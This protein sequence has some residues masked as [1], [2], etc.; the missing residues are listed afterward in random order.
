MV[1]SLYDITPLESLVEQGYT[2]LTPNYRLARHIKTQWDVRRIAAGDRV[3]EPL[4]VQ[5]LESWLLAQWELAVSLNLL[6]PV[7]PLSA[8]QA[9]ELWRQVIVQQARQ[10]PEFRLLRPAA[11]AEL[12]SQAYEALRRWRVD[13]RRPSIRQSFELE[14]DC[15]SFLSW[16]TL[17]E[18]RLTASRQCTLPDCLTQLPALAGRLP[19]TPVALV[20]CG[21]IAPLLRAA[22][23]A[24][25][26]TTVEV[27]PQ[28]EPGECLFHSFSD[29]R[30]ELQ[31]VAAWA[32]G[33]HRARP[34]ATIGI[35]LSNT[36]DGVALEYLLRREFNCLGDSYTGLP[37]NFSSGIPL[38]QTPLVR[39]AL[40]A[41]SMGLEH[42]TVQVVESLLHSRFLDLADAHSALAQYFIMHLYTEGRQTLTVAAVQHSATHIQLGEQKGLVLGQCLRAVQGMRALRHRAR[43]S[44]WAER[45]SAVLSLWGWP[46]VGTLDS[47]EFQQLELWYRTLDE[48][49]A[50]D[51]VCAPIDFGDALRLLRECCSRQIS[52][53][54][55]ADSAVQ[56]L[57]PLEAAGLAF[58]HLWLCGMQGAS[59]PAAPRPN[60]LI[61][62]GLQAQLR[63][64]HASAEREWDFSEALITQY[65]RTCRT[66]H[67]SYS[68]HIDG[69]G[70]LPSA[71]L[72][73][74]TYQPVPDPPLVAPQWS[75]SYSERVI[76]E[77]ADNRGPCLQGEQLAT[78][79]G[80]SSLLE[81]QSRCPFRAFALHRL[82]V[83]PLGSFN[84]A[85]SQAERGA[86]L[87]GALFALWGEICDSTALHAL[88]AE[89]Q[90]HTIARAVQ[91]AL[92][93]IPAR[94]R[95]TLGTT[96]WLLEAQRLASLLHEWLTVERTR[97]AFSVLQREEGKT[98]EL[99]S[100][101][102]Q[103]RV[104]R[105]DLL[106]DGSRVIIDYKSAACTVQDWLGDRPARPQ[107]LL[108]G[109]AEPG[110]AGAL[111]FAQLRPRD[112]RY[113]GLGRVAAA[114]GISTDISR[115]VQPR[116]NSAD[117]SSLNTHWQQVLERIATAFV[118]GDAPVTPLTPATCTHCGL[119]PLC[120]VKLS[121]PSAGAPSE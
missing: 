30:A 99:A 121:A 84:V 18:E 69:V 6:P 37:V 1:P 120:R 74:F 51:A 86:L 9:L 22:L 71:L 101:P 81:D 80:G 83:A 45:Y 54:Q 42:T 58:E 77:V 38:A 2:L 15:G 102:I 36:V 109:I 79:K 85:L 98:L 88:S 96:Y 114:D 24:L 23:E 11:A 113:V 111:A 64:P 27:K 106:P 100:L 4:P 66:L 97:S 53:P 7:T 19:P 46:G 48:L 28:T 32:A 3:W 56:V 29:P 8:A 43:P 107:L 55:T 87:H 41:L 63:M 20:E 119:Q 115:V 105:M 47:L 94:K 67:A 91:T 10:S 5:P 90:Q 75:M 33:L 60:P 62:V 31:A 112:C 12:A 78:M 93:A 104:D 14:R 50:Y 118:A 26:S 103:L 52:Q 117:W 17:F 95:A 57:G 108:Y 89:D 21:E 92:A 61:P 110:A 34:T 25:C 76:E 73:G 44:I 72:A 16:L 68:R 65:A 13:M 59:W 40:A 70:D 116:M 35:V 39:D 82:Q 49:R